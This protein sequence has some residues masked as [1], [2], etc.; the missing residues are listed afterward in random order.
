VAKF[1][2]IVVTRVRQLLRGRPGGT[3]EDAEARLGRLFPIVPFYSRGG[4]RCPPRQVLILPPQVPGA[5]RQVGGVGRHVV[6]R[7]ATSCAPTAS[8]CVTRRKA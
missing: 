8:P 5:P 4:A 1:D 7:V 3:A 6:R 2:A